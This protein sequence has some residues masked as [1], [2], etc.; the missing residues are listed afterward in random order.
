MATHILGIDVAKAKLDVMLLRPDDTSEH[1]VFDNTPSGFRKMDKWLKQ[2]KAGRVH[3]CLE[4]TG[5]YGD[6]VA[7]H[8]HEGGH[9]V[10]VINPARIKAYGDSQL[11]RN[12]TDK[13]DAA[14]IADFCRTQK[15][16]AWTPPPAH[17]LEL[18][19][20]V[21][22]MD[23]L[24]TMRLQ[25]E[26]RLRTVQS[27]VVR[28][29]LETH[30]AFLK[31][32]IADLR[33]RIKRHID[34]DPDLKND[35]DLLTS[36]PGIGDITA[37]KFLAEVR[38]VRRFDSARELV[39]YAGLNP[40]QHYS[41]RSVHRKIGISKT[42]NAA[43]RKAFFCPAMAARNHNPAMSALADRLHARG[44][45]KIVAIVAIMRKL[46]HLAYAILISGRPFDPNFAAQT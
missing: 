28:K 41:G 27:D 25:E 13:L 24:D 9:M 38:D 43:L 17:W 35:R 14:L 32:Q 46:L 33:R 2:R 12:K 19:A 45:T 26:N 6:D 7:V 21:R 11:A 36:I 8:L 23:A 1:G 5:V 18:R 29:Q 44:K 20:M 40:K 34:Q 31:A 42:G 30:I 3:V 37:A 22:H 39:A 4:A 10:S 16:P 15:P